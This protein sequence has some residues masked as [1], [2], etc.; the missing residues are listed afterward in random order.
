MAIIKF[1]IIDYLSGLTNFV[2]DKAVLNRIAVECGVAE[3]TSYADLTETDRDHCRIA[4]LETVLFGPYQTASS[5]S[6]HGS[7]SLTVGAQTITEAAMKGIREELRRLYAKYNENDK[8]ETLNSTEG[9][10][11]WIDEWNWL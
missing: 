10:M 8:L 2:F 6:Q 11:K 1:D 4:L 3:A 5:T 7:Y 9:E